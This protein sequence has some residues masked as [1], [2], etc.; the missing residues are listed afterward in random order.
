MKT[1]S[2]QMEIKRIDNENEHQYIWRLCEAKENGLLDLD[3]KGLAEIFNKELCDD[4]T[5]YKDESA[6]RKSYQYA[7]MYYDDVFK[8]KIKDESYLR[9]L[10]QKEEDIKKERY[11]LLDVRAE[12][13]RRIKNEARLEDRLDLLEE[14]IKKRGIER[15]TPCTNDKIKVESDNDLLI[16]LSDLHIGQTFKSFSG[17][18]NSEI[19][20]KRLDLYFQKIVEIQKRHNSEN[21]YLSLQGDLISNSIHKSLAIT[22]RENVIKQ[23][24]IASDL[25]TSFVYSLSSV[26]KNVYISS[27]CGNHSRLDRK[28]DALKDERLDDLIFW[29][30]NNM[31]SHL[32][33]VLI[34]TSVDNTFAS[35]NIRGKEYIACHGDYDA[36]SKNGI[37]NLSMMIG[38]FP[39]AVTFGH[40]HTCSMCEENGIKLIRGGC[41]SGSGDE[42]T[43]QKRLIGKPSQMV[44]VCTEKGVETYYPVELD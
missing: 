33:N 4:E 41:F 37:S 23:I 18:Y 43:I 8:D 31:T 30:I 9:E 29:Y 42:Y 35:I 39:Y 38:H 40:L 10:I 3:W 22:N 2:E 19:A 24:I 5:E 14:E 11:R 28:E 44:C 26:F 7:K 6:Y 27:V 15:Y 34:I 13:N 12:Y 17:E 20:S 1:R 36:Y 32:K 16:I 25:L 21:C